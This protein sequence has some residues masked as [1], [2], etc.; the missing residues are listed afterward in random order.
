MRS[1]TLLSDFQKLLERDPLLHPEE[2]NLR[3]LVEEV[4]ATLCGPARRTNINLYS[5]VE[6]GYPLFILCDRVKLRGLLLVL[7]ESIINTSGAGTILLKIKSI[8]LRTVGEMLEFSLTYSPSEL[9]KAKASQDIAC[10]FTK[11]QA[12]LDLCHHAL[13]LM[14]GELEWSTKENE[15]LQCSIRVP[16]E[17]VDKAPQIFQQPNSLQALGQEILLLDEDPIRR[18]VLIKQCKHWGLRVRCIQN[19]DLILNLTI[20]NNRFLAALISS[21]CLKPGDAL[22]LFAAKNTHSPAIVITNGVDIPVVENWGKLNNP[23]TLQELFEALMAFYRDRS[24]LQKK[25]SRQTDKISPVVP[26]ELSCDGILDSR[27]LRSRMRLGTH[28]FEELVRVFLKDIPQFIS[29]LRQLI[30]E[31]RTSLRHLAHKCKGYSGNLGAI[32]LSSI[33]D[34]IE[35][36]AM[37]GSTEQCY[38]LVDSL[39]PAFHETKEYL[40][41]L[42]C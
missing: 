40:L 31:E 6:G 24:F 13:V 32:K 30:E 25:S 14:S 17:A 16:L 29:D 8:T 20:K 9:E 23:F 39:I 10:C 18:E 19:F 11:E 1:V 37:D 27:I 38:R 28:F 22:K 42:H 21:K 26:I 3:F 4:F 34:E 36:Q 15:S 7:L 41:S 35:K 2:F 12:I 33:C 5:C